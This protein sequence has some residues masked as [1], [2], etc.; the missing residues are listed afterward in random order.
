MFHAINGPFCE[1]TGWSKGEEPEVEAS[2]VFSSSTPGHR[3]TPYRTHVHVR[4]CTHAHTDVHRSRPDPQ[5]KSTSTS[6]KILNPSLPGVP[7][8]GCLRTTH[9]FFRTKKGVPHP[10]VA[11]GRC[12]LL[13]P[14]VSRVAPPT[15]R[16]QGGP[17]RD[18]GDNVCVLQPQTPSADSRG[19]AGARTQMKG[20]FSEVQPQR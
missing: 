15:R 13:R 5:G 17:L 16:E 4:V 2:S 6:R 3:F 20:H 14:R 1:R 9:E 12:P 8:M 10:S 11:V 19:C 7:G 18:H